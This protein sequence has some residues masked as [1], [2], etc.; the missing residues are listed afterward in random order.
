M[1][2]PARL[3][4]LDCGLCQL[5]H[6]Y[7]PLIGQ[8]RLD[9][10][11][12]SVALTYRNSQL[13]YLNQ[14]AHLLE[15]ADPLPTTLI[16]IHALIFASELIHSS[17]IIHTRHNLK[18]V[19]LTYQE[20]VGVVRRGDFNSTCSLLGIRVFIGYNR[21]LSSD[22]RQY[23]GLA[24]QFRISLIVRIYSDCDISEH[25]LRPGSCNCNA[26]TAILRRIMEVP[27]LALYIFVIYLCI[28]QSSHAVGA[29]VDKSVTLIDHTLFIQPDKELGYCLIA[30]LVHRKTLSAPIA[31]ISKLTTLP[32]NVSAILLFPFPSAFKEGLSS[33]ILLILTCLLVN[34]VV[35]LNLCCDT[36][37]VTAR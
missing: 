12:T 19:S 3:S 9:S 11:M 33:Y 7:E 18:T 2:E 34:S 20:V 1:L 28:R 5:L 35:N 24:Y 31:G 23:Y 6:P 16:S 13:L 15:V 17:I 32:G 37:M 10:I 26:F 8:L 14:E 27:I 36:G 25:S 30:A 21:N 22:N 4:R 29:P